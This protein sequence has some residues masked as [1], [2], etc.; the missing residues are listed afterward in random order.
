MGAIFSEIIKIANQEP[1][2]VNYNCPVCRK[3]GKPPNAAGRF[4]LL[5]EYEW[6]CNGCNEIFYRADVCV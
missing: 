6:Q 3:T 1:I 5:N 2:K 4:F